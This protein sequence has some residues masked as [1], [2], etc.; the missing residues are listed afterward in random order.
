MTGPENDIFSDIIA[1]MKHDF[2]DPVTTEILTAA[3]YYEKEINALPYSKR[4][5]VI[6]ERLTSLNASLEYTGIG[7]EFVHVSGKVR[8][9]SNAISEIDDE[10]RLD[11]DDIDA[12]QVHYP[13]LAQFCR[14]G[15]VYKDEEG[16]YFN[17]DNE[18][19]ICG[20][21]DAGSRHIETDETLEHESRLLIN[22]PASDDQDYSEAEIFAYL[23]E[24]VQLV[25]VEPSLQKMQ[26]E[27]RTKYPELY[28]QITSFPEEAKTVDIV[29]FLKQY[30]LE[31]DWSL[32]PDC[33][34]DTKAVI[35]DYVERCLIERL[36]ID[37]SFHTVQVDGVVFGLTRDGEWTTSTAKRRTING[38][39][40]GVRLVPIEK[41]EPSE[42]D[43][44]TFNLIM[45]HP[46]ASHNGG[47]ELIFI[48]VH[49][50]TSTRNH[51]ASE[52]IFE[53]SRAT[54]PLEATD[55][56]QQVPSSEPEDDTA[57]DTLAQPTESEHQHPS[58]VRHVYNE[59]DGERILEETEQRLKE[60]IEYASFVSSLTFRTDQELKPYFDKVEELEIKFGKV[61]NQHL[62]SVE[63]SGPGV[64]YIGQQ[65]N[66]D[67]ED[68]ED[69]KLIELSLSLKDMQSDEFTVM[70]GQPITTE[71]GRLTN[72]DG[73]FSVKFFLKLQKIGAAENE[74]RY[75]DQ[76]AMIEYVPRE[77][78]SVELNS[79]RASVAVPD[80]DRNRSVLEG[81]RAIAN[82]ATDEILPWQIDELRREMLAVDSSEYVG[83][84]YWS[85]LPEVAGSIEGNPELLKK[86][87]S[88]FRDMFVDKQV[89]ISGEVF[90]ID[91]DA[92]GL[93]QVNGFVT[94]VV[95]SRPNYP[96]SE[97]MI[98]LV[99]RAT[100]LT[101]YVPFSKITRV[102]V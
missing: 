29:K 15:K 37:K 79:D 8:I 76:F 88:V 45:M 90:D 65:F 85:V 42:P 4:G 92:T 66:R 72:D 81:I 35:R 26:Y 75:G 100:N 27:L 38:V 60:L 48:P 97:P 61:Y 47:Y 62:R 89:R 84:D 6:D 91:G 55:L 98:E 77:T 64:I 2:D 25:P 83:L 78:F 82:V 73:S 87:Q 30:H 34:E 14:E 9:D 101:F 19:F 16:Y 59:D 13:K 86:I 80:A 11:D 12:L 24:L 41:T 56:G 94:D 70:R 20:Y 28:A 5:D 67:D 93:E 53:T 52:P 69:G 39:P 58:D 31:F 1:G 33:D 95:V 3:D 49:S 46:V 57:S 40:D 51:R 36:Q 23:D 74:I 32:Y 54:L 71:M 10:P 50:I 44:Y 22:L 99:N 63:V 17:L 18:R 7:G 96:V 43:R 68:S 21:I 102:E